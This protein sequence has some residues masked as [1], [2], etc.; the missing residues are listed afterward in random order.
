MA[1]EPEKAWLEAIQNGQYFVDDNPYEESFMKTARI[2]FDFFLHFGDKLQVKRYKSLNREP[3][4]MSIVRVC[5]RLRD[6]NPAPDSYCIETNF[7][8]RFFYTFPLPRLIYE[9]DLYT[10]LRENHYEL[11]AELIK[12]YP[13]LKARNKL[14]QVYVKGYETRPN[15]LWGGLAEWIFIISGSLKITLTESVDKH[16]IEM[17][18]WKLD[19]ERFYEDAK[20]HKEIILNKGQLLF[21]PS[22]WVTTR[23]ALDNTY[24]F[25][26]E[27][28]HRECLPVMLKLFNMDAGKRM[29]DFDRERDIRAVLWYQA[30]SL[31]HN[32]GL[33]SSGMSLE[34]I[35]CFKNSLL[36][37]KKSH[38][39]NELLALDGVY[40][41]NS[42]IFD[43]AKTASYFVDWV[44]QQHNRKRKRTETPL[45]TVS[46]TP[47]SR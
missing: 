19:E 15:R 25:G 38:D 27:F 42:F 24:T 46:E 39:A 29:I 36:A 32:F 10:D 28:I 30:M 44:S 12:P 3:T 23:Q 35:T 13:Y 17:D 11:M 37:W 5:K 9:C 34:V 4:N 45:A 26:G 14:L 33:A 21:I 43:Y 22:G 41:P 2:T 1:T 20:C 31:A 7:D 6:K 8:D 16:D 47:E 18:S 40:V